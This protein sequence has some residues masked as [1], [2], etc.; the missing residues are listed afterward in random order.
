MEIAAIIGKESLMIALRGSPSNVLTPF[1]RES[2][3]GVKGRVSIGNSSSTGKGKHVFLFQ[4][5]DNIYIN[6]Y[7]KLYVL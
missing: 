2:A 6:H 5:C 3:D 4:Y 1:V 7:E